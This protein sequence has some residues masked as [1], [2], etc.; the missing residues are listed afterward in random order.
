V[1]AGYIDHIALAM[2]PAMREAKRRI[3]ADIV[4]RLG[5]GLW[6][7]PPSTS[8][9]RTGKDQAITLTNDQA[10]SGRDVPMTEIETLRVK[11]RAAMEKFAM[12]P[13]KDL[14]RSPSRRRHLLV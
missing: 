14:G 13:S 6:G 11:A 9:C 2:W 1:S 5:I 4:K 8:D 10:F 12:A 7:W 3:S